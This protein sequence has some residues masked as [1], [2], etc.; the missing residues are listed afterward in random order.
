M[1]NTVDKVNSLLKAKKITITGLSLKLKIP[2]SVVKK[3]IK[4]DAFNHTES[5]L[6][7]HLR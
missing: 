3:K 1:Q 5:F 6:I 4:E 2:E 7:K